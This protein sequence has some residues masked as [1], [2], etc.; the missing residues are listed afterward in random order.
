M[1]G[2]L[3]VRVGSAESPK[4]DFKLQFLSVELSL[5][6]FY[7]ICPWKK[8]C[9]IETDVFFS[10]RTR[11][12]LVQLS[13]FPFSSPPSFLFFSTISFFPPP[14]WFLTFLPLCSIH[15]TAICEFLFQSI[16]FSVSS[17]NMLKRRRINVSRLFKWLENY[18]FYR[19]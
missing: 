16:F 2:R 12:R 5:V 17:P 6:F 4:I 3:L 9:L 7:R 19:L 10:A 1:L 18:F 11:A 13:H 15:G 14:R 8:V